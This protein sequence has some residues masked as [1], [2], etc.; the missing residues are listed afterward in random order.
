MAAFLVWNVGRKNLD[1]LVQNLV[2]QHTI[3]VLLLVEYYPSVSGSSLSTLLLN[4]GLVMLDQ[5]VIRPAESPSFPEDQLEIVSS[6]GTVSLLAPDGTPD[7]TVGSD[8]LPIVF[9]W[10][11]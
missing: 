3:D 10:N 6:V 9:H 8:H 4:D 11:L 7:T 1:S 5:V 2:R